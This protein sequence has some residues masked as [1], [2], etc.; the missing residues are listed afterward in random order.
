MTQN[1]CRLIGLTGGIATGKSTVSSILN[2]KGYIVIDADKIAREVVEVNKPAYNKIIGGFGEEI[3]NKDR[4]L[5]RK[6]LGEI[7]FND[8]ISRKKLNEITHPYIFEAI[9]QNVDMLCR[10]R[11]LLFLDI[12]LLFEQYNLWEEYEIKFHEIW[13]VY[14]QKNMQIDRLIDR[15]NISK[16]EALKRIE[17]QMNMEYKKTRSSKIIDNSG[18]IEHLKKQIDE[19]LLE[20]F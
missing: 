13:L 3:L 8:E 6:A 1:N 10:E 5:N 2:E 4:T 9:K 17:S 20:L 14:L 18:D 15:D 16:E 7:I 12:P 11:E 19:L